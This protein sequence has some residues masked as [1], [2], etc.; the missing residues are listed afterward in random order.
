MKMPDLKLRGWPG[1][2]YGDRETLYHPLYSPELAPTN[3]HLFHSLGNHLRGKFFANEA[4]L[5]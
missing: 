4:D 3:Y 1:I 2:P 5:Q